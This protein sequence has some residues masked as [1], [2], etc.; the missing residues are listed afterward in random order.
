YMTLAN[1]AAAEFLV[2][3]NLKWWQGLKPEQR[4]VIAKASADAE[5]YVREK[6]A[7]AEAKAQETVGKAGVEI[8][9]PS[10]EELAAFVKATAPI[11]ETYLKSGGDLAAKLLP[12]AD[13]AAK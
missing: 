12:I 11:R 5:A 8:H 13:A 10:A 2:Q 9:I 3:A 1:Y 4:E 6:V 7:E